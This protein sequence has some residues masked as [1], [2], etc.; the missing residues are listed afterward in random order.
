[1]SRDVTSV[2]AHLSVYTSQFKF[3]DEAT[4]KQ[5]YAVKEYQA[6]VPVSS[7]QTRFKLIK[8]PSTLATIVDEQVNGF[9]ALS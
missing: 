5:I 7:T 8:S 9:L 6:I 4:V 3:S 1:M 2:F